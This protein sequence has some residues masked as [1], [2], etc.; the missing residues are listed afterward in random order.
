MK[1]IESIWNGMSS[2]Q[3]WATIVIG[4][5]AVVA[6]GGVALYAVS[7]GGIVVSTGAVT[8]GLGE[9]APAALAGGVAL[10]GARS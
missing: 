8:V 7:T 6:T 4:G 10:L 9:A 3:K 1:H 2:G 5:V